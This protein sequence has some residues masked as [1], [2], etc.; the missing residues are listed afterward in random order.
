MKIM[1]LKPTL[2]MPSLD[3]ANTTGNG[4]SILCQQSSKQ[5]H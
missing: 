3:Q 4:S 1:N 5:F 2:E